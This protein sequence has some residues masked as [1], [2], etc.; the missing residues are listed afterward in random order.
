MSGFLQGLAILA[1]AKPKWSITPEQA[2]IWR[3][4]VG[5]DVP[6]EVLLSA[7]LQLSR[8]SEFDPTPAAWRARALQLMNGPRL[9]AAEAWDE[10]MRNRRAPR[11]W[12]RQDG[13]PRSLTAEPKWSSEAVRRAAESVGWDS[14]DWKLDQIPTIRA[15]F[16]N[17]YEALAD[18]RDEIDAAQDA[19]RALPEMVKALSQRWTPQVGSGPKGVPRTESDV[20]HE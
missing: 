6:D 20:S 19:Q 9:T 2:A 13:V 12:R 4:I 15:Q 3:V 11:V 17:A 14:P 7:A 1:A 16:R 18:K 8:E 10:L 5:T